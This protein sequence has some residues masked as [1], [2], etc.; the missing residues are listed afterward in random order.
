[1]RF[2]RRRGRDDAVDEERRGQ[3]EQPD[4]EQ[5]EMSVLSTIAP[6]R[7]SPM[8]PPMPNIA[9]IIP[10]ATERRSA[11]SS[12]LMIPKASGNSPAA[13]PWMTAPGDDHLDRNPRAR[14]RSS[15][16]RR[17]AAR[18][19]RTRALPEQVAELARERRAHRRRQQ[20]PREHPGR[21]R[22]LRAELPA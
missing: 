22:G 21:R 18:R 9:E 2:A 11:G 20:E 1:V 6:D 4:P 7:G 12:S 8:P 13:T 17:S 5:P 10:M 19:S 14:R 15:R 3:R 16:R